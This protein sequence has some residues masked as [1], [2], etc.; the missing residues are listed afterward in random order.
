[1]R[2]PQPPCV[3]GGTSG[4]V[5]TESTMRPPSNPLSLG[6]ATLLA[7]VPALAQTSAQTHAPES[8]DA[9]S[10]ETSPEISGQVPASVPAGTPAPSESAP[11]SAQAAPSPAP[12]GPPRADGAPASET[13]VPAASPTSAQPDPPPLAPPPG[14]DVGGPP[15]P[16]S[17]AAWEQPAAPPPVPPEVPTYGLALSADRLFGLYSWNMQVDN[18]EGSDAEN[19]G[20]MVSLLYGNSAT[21]RGASINPFTVPRFGIDA[22]LNGLTLGGTVGFYSSTGDLEVDD[23]DESEIPETPEQSGYFFGPRLG[24]LLRASPTVQLWFRGGLAYYSQ[25]RRTEE[26]SFTGSCTAMVA[27]EETENMTAFSVDPVLVWEPVAHV[28]ITVGPVLDLGLSGEWELEGS[29]SCSSGSS[30]DTTEMSGKAE[31]TYSNYGVTAGL[32]LLL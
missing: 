15:G 27:V 32:A 11:S 8:P 23:V 22:I 12:A 30:I 5:N 21:G 31:Q 28:G 7:A 6:V 16:S 18:D 14:P 1:M 19:T 24:Y 4:H 26:P 3:A 29:G 9:P 10:S 25:T 13:A 2:V 17:N 20:T